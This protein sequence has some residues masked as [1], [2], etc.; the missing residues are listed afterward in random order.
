MK[1][2]DRILFHPK[3]Q[4]ALG[5]IMDWE[6]DRQFC[7]HDIG[8]FLDVARLAYIHCL[9]QDVDVKKDVVYAAALL[10]DIGRYRQYEAGVPHEE[11]S[12]HLADEILPEC[13][14]SEEEQAQIRGA[15]LGHR[16]RGAEETES[17][18]DLLY[19]ADKMSRNCFACASREACDWP[20]DKMNMVIRDQWGECR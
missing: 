7:R 19:R 17:L 5:Q 11:A 15:I 3:Y 20:A 9:E 6:Q 13:S 14:F 10:H 18:A 4:Y 16:R 8:H 12:V 2:I 1:R